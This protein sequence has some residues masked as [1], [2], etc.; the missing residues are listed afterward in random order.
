MKDLDST[1]E[2]KNNKSNEEVIKQFEQIRK[3]ER[4]LRWLTIFLLITVLISL[5]IIYFFYSNYK[6]VEKAI[7]E[8]AKNI[9]DN[10]PQN[11]ILPQEINKN[12][13]PTISFENSSLSKIRGLSEEIAENV[14]S[15]QN[16]KNIEEIVDEYYNEPNIN[17]FIE[18]FRNDPDMK[19]IFEAPEKERPIKM[20]KKMNDPIFMQKMAK[21]FLSN[22]QLLQS[23]TKMATDPRIQQL[24]KEGTQKKEKKQKINKN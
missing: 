6:K 8:A 23:I 14:T 3:R 16:I 24:L 9:E 4:Y 11:L 15:T 18:K 21:E 10:V 7:E 5:S 1:N 19:E 17:E 22:P 20:F 13:I 12:Q 2:S